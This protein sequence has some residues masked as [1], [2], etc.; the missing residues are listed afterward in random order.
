MRLLAVLLLLSTP[1]QAEDVCLT[2]CEVPLENGTD[3][4]IPISLEA[5]GF[6]ELIGCEPVYDLR[7]ASEPVIAWNPIVKPIN[8]TMLHLYPGYTPEADGNEKIFFQGQW[9]RFDDP[10]I[11]EM[12]EMNNVI[13]SA[14]AQPV[15]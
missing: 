3:A 10:L 7:D 11:G 4:T 12:F 15:S 9:V 13:S 1:L 2:V 14:C 5:D 8:P 6:W